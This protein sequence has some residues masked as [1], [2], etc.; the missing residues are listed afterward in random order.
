MEVGDP[1]GL[2]ACWSL[3]KRVDGGETKHGYRNLLT[4]KRSMVLVSTGVTEI[5]RKSVRSVGL[6][7]LGTGLID[8]CFH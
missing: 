7:T 5:G 6:V 3:N 1:E 8:A 2:N 4:T